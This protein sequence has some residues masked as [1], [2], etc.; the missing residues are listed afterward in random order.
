MVVDEEDADVF[1]GDGGDAF[2]VA[3]QEELI[4]L[5]VDERGSVGDVDGAL[6]HGQSLA[7]RMRPS[8]STVTLRAWRL[9]ELAVTTNFCFLFD[10][11][12]SVWR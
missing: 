9:I 7:H 6:N 8:G 1:A 3:R 4:I 12:A 11:L 2:G 10:C 5:D